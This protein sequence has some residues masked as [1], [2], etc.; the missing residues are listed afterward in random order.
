MKMLEVKGIHIAERDTQRSSEVRKMGH[1]WN[2]WSVD[3]FIAEGLHQPS[4]LGWGTHEKWK[5]PNAVDHTYGEKYAISLDQP[6]MNTMIKSWCPTPGPQLGFMITHDESMSITQY[7]SLS[8]NGNF[9]YKP[10][11]FY[12]YHPCEDAV[13]SC[14][15]ILG[16]GEAPP[17]EKWKILNKDI[18]EGMDELGVLIYGHKKNAYWYGSQLDIHRTRKIASDQNATALE[19]TSTVPAGVVWA[20]ENPEQGLVTADELDYK[21][22]LEVQRYYLEPMYASYTD[23]NPLKNQ[24]H[25]FQKD[26]YDHSDPWQFKNMLLHK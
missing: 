11:V 9:T 14:L 24:A 15:E 16:T 18:T 4:E 13:N 20:L 6:G 25:E 1:F 19:V 22:C 2:T 12:A 8:E 26:A 7:Y 21:R 3:G 17:P 5:P 10:T 23:W